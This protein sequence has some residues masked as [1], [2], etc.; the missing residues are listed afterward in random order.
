[1]SSDLLKTG[2]MIATPRGMLED[3]SGNRFAAFA[4]GLGAFLKNGHL[5]SPEL[6]LRQRFT[7]IVT[8][9]EIEA[10]EIL[11][12]KA[13]PCE[14]CDERCISSCPVNAFEKEKV[15]FECEGVKNFFYKKNRVRCDWSIRYALVGDSGFKYLGSKTDEHPSSEISEKELHEAL[16][17]HDPIKRHRMVVMEPCMI[18]CPFFK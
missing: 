14:E 8:D 15:N 9:A 17:K 2:S 6:G 13:S 4:S 5:Y 16:Q 10:D 1:M 3:L 7:A 11:N 12:L 18:N